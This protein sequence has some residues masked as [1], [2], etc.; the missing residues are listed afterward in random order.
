MQRVNP[1]RS[2][3]DSSEYRLARI[4]R[5]A[6]APF[7]VDI[8]LTNNCN[9]MCNMCAR[10]LMTR[11]RGFM[12]KEIWIRIL[13]ECIKTGTPIRF[14]RWGEP[15]LHRKIIDWARKVKEAGL[16][17]HITNNGLVITEPQMQEIVNMGLDSI[18]FSMQG[19][20][21]KGYEKMRNNKEYDKL[22]ANI[23]KLVEIRGNNKAPYIHISSTMT[24]ETKE[25]ID[26]F[27]EY[28]SNIVDSV[29]TGKTSFS[30]FDGED[31]EYIP[32][33]EVYQKLSI[34]WDGKVTACCGDYDNL[35]TVGDIKKESL[36]EIF[37]GEKLKSIRTILD[38]KGHKNLAL[39]SKCHKAYENF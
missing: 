19:A 37:N 24:D 5:T 6:K 7:I 10:R 36:V 29:D 4:K 32:C 23:L 16:L 1:F 34:D 18:I 9:L 35:L 27:K 3:Y 17:L 8:E 12:D 15:F 30:R 22:H 26:K 39:C 38:N 13:D 14:I 25:E 28:W 31:G 2:I 33:N 11:E 21:K 20:T